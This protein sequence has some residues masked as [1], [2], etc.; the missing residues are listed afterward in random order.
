MATKG[1]VEVCQEIV[2]RGGE[3]PNRVVQPRRKWRIFG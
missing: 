3:Y 2:D 1:V